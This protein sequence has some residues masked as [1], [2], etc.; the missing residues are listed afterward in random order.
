MGL[1][2]GF[3]L[4]GGASLTHYAFDLDDVKVDGET[5]NVGEPINV[6]VPAI[7]VGPR[8]TF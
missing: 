2:D 5:V 6:N 1:S 4:V 8:F 7:F 3:D